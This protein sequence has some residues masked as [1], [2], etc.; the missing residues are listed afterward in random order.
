MGWWRKLRCAAL[1]MCCFCCGQ[2]VPACLL[3]PDLRVTEL[4]RCTLT[5]SLL[6]LPLPTHPAGMWRA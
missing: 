4:S 6:T 1:Q 5:L 2:T 3:H